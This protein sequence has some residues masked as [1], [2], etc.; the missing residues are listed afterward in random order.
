MD[1]P[2][3]PRNGFFDAF[4]VYP[5][6]LLIDWLQS[7]L[8]GSYGLAILAVTILVRLLI[9]PLTVNQ[10]KN[11]AK[12]QKIQ[13]EMLKIREK[14]KKDPEKMQKEMMRL[15]Q[16]YDVNPMGSY[17]PLLAQAPVFFALFSAVR[18]SPHIKT[19][20]FLWL[21][22]GVRDPYYVLPVLAAIVTFLSMWVSQ[23]LNPMV[24]NNAQMTLMLIIMPLVT[25]FVTLSFPSAL[26]LYWIY[27]SAFTVVQTWLL[28]DLVR[29]MRPAPKEEDTVKR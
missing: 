12:M 21:E 26:Q 10:Y 27:S 16:E 23:R 18:R 20:S 6:S 17:F 15:F 7:V 5:I 14:Y 1:V 8:W 9:L 19:A 29:A 25:L 3:D 2:P 11:M 4:F 22:L 13:P 24:Q 28:K